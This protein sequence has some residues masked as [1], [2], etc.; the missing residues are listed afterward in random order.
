MCAWPTASTFTVRFLAVL[1]GAAA[2]DCCFAILSLIRF[3]YYLVAIFLLAM[4]LRLP[5]RV[6]ALVLNAGHEQGRPLR[7]RTPR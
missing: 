2:A 5:L 7:W 3:N 4:V 6:R 1:A